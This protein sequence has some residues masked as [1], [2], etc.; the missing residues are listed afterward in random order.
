MAEFS[1]VSCYNVHP[2]IKTWNQDIAY[3]FL[4]VVPTAFKK[5]A[6]GF[7]RQTVKIM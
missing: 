4:K 3:K 6:S 5:K 2:L 1:P 7:W